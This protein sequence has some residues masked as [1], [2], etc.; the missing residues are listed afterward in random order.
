MLTLHIYL[1]NLKIACRRHYVG[2]KSKEIEIQR[3]TIPY[4]IQVT[5]AGIPVELKMIRKL[6]LYNATWINKYSWAM[7]ETN[8]VYIHCG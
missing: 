2:P 5:I 1:V 3:Y 4:F 8:Q 6:I 7:S